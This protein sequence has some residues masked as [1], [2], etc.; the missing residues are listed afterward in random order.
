M[1]PAVEGPL[2]I[3]MLTYNVVDG[4]N[5]LRARSLAS[6]LARRGH[7]VT[8]VAGRSS[9]G[10]AV[11]RSAIDGVSVVQYPELAPHRVRNGGL[12]V[13]DTLA[14]C[15]MVQRTSADVVH[16]FGHRPAAA[17]PALVRQRCRN[18]PF[19]L[20][21]ADL[22]GT[23]GIAGER[24]P[25]LR[26]TLGVADGLGERRACSLADAVTVPCRPLARMARRLRPSRD[27]VHLLPGGASPDVVYPVPRERA[28]RRYGVDDDAHV[29]VFA[30]DS[31][32]DAALLAE[33]FVRVAEAD[34][35]ALLLLAGDSGT[36]IRRLL[37]GRSAAGR[38][39][40]VGHVPYSDLGAVLSC[41]DVALLPLKQDSV[42][43]HRFPNKICDYLAAGRPVVASP[44]GDMAEIVTDQGVGL[45]AP[46]DPTSLADAVLRLFGSADLRRDMG[47]RARA[48]AVERLSWERH[49]DRLAGLYSSLLAARL[50]PRLAA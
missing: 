38:V 49:T 25:L 17:L 42:N 8:L 40:S 31:T 34:T 28:R 4:S 26:W 39:L 18:T 14:R 12:G 37:Q 15:F 6:R 32:Y 43:T 50:E 47:T 48:L 16:A 24:S 3:L 2:R 46:G 20:D 22:W 27:G 5:Y 41:G 19:V 23:G 9:P 36:R 30:A 44:V 11:R 21:W 29:V 13:V 35:R 10:L 7:T 45:T 33:T 1:N